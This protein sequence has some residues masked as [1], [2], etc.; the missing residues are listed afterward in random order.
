MVG[1]VG[2]YALG[3]ICSLL[4]EPSLSDVFYQGIVNTFTMHRGANWSV[5]DMQHTY[6]LHPLLLCVR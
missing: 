3:I 2:Y 5:K 6:V 4:S 1:F